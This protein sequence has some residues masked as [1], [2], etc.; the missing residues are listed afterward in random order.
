M[1]SQQKQR[2]INRSQL[3]TVRIWQEELGDGQSEWRGKVQHV[4]TGEALYF[5]DWSVLVT[6]LLKMLAEP[7]PQTE[8]E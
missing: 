2:Q 7:S 6:A 1:D 5:R 3:F 4:H 8:I